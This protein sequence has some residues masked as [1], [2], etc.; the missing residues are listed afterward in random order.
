MEKTIQIDGRNITFRCTAGTLRRYRNQFGRE[1]FAD[2]AK[3]TEAENGS[4][5]NFT[6]APIE[7][8]IWVMAKTADDTI[9]DPDA[10][11]D[12]FDDFS[13]IDV[14]T[15]LEK[16]ILHSLKRKNSPA[17]VHPAMKRKRKKKHR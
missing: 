11:Y 13:V 4:F 14:F 5:D 7:D 2:L 15:S 16:L 3:L 6:F 9:P 1:F 12:G 10:W 8:I 17:A